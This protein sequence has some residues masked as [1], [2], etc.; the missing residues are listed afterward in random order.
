[1]KEKEKRQVEESQVYRRKMEEQE[2]IREPAGIY[3]L[4]S[5]FYPGTKLL[6]WHRLFEFGNPAE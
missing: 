4:L 2:G 6:F 3:S 1:M 5:S